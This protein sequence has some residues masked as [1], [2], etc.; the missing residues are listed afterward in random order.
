MDRY[1]SRIHAQNYPNKVR[2]LSFDLRCKNSSKKL[3]QLKI[4]MPIRNVA[5][6]LK[7]TH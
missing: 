7:T 6:K 3:R 5:Q 4:G 1:R 2:T